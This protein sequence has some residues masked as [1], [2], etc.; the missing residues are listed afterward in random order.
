MLQVYSFIHHYLS[1]L[2]FGASGLQIGKL[3]LSSYPEER[4]KPEDA[5][6]LVAKK[7]LEEVKQMLTDAYPKTVDMTLSIYRVKEVGFR[8]LE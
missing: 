5:E 4:A 3:K 6:E 1:H 8:N 7:A 2:Y